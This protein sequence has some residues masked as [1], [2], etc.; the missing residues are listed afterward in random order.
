MPAQKRKAAARETLVTTAFFK[1]RSEGLEP[2]TYK[3]VACCSI[4]LSYDGVHDARWSRAVCVRAERDSP[5]YGFSS[6]FPSSLC[7][8]AVQQAHGRLKAQRTQWRRE[9]DSNPRYDFTSYNGLANRRLQPL[10]HLS[11]CVARV[12]AQRLSQ[13]SRT[14]IPHEGP[15]PLAL[16]SSGP[17]VRSLVVRQRTQHAHR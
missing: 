13:H 8:T 3:F 10:G 1:S 2:P 15:E 16:T 7:R 6:D 12:A 4:Q 11:R 14:T 9:R 5:E 17:W